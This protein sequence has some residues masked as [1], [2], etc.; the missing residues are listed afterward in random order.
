MRG[1]WLVSL[2]PEDPL[3][4]PEVRF[5]VGCLVALA[6]IAGSLVLVFLVAFALQPP[7]W[8]QVLIGVALIGGGAVLGLLV[9]TALGGPEQPREGPRK[10]PEEEPGAGP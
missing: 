1:T 9:A 4:R 10:L 8:V 2:N 5:G 7:A 3:K 6:A